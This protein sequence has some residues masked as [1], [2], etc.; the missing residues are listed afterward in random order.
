MI[1]S[2]GK[3]DE[4]DGEVFLKV[5]EKEGISYVGW[6]LVTRATEYR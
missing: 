3:Q 5:E 1:E 2:S 6:I 4:G